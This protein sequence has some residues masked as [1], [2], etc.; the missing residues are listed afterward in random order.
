[1]QKV[2]VVSESL[3][4]SI[5]W[6]LMALDRRILDIISSIS[7]VQIKIQKRTILSYFIIVPGYFI[8]IAQVSRK[9]K[10]A[11]GLR[12]TIQTLQAHMK[13]GI[14]GY[15]I[16]ALDFKAQVKIG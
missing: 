12:A 7:S 11:H 3:L 6:L 16:I 4:K 2:I 14:S 15:I 5:C 1:M 8:V 9:A 10:V 13:D